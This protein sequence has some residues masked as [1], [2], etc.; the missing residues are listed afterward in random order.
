MR[1]LLISGSLRSGSANSAMLRTAFEVAPEPIEPMAFSGL[2]RLPHF[3][4]DD[5][6][7]PLPPPVVGLRAA[8]EL[9]D[10]VL[11]C[12]PEYAGALPG[13][14]KNLLEWTV[15]GTEMYRRPVGW[16]NV[17]GGGRGAATHEQ[18]RSV[19][20]YVNAEIVETACSRIPVARS[21]IGPDGRIED[22]EIRERLAALL[23]ALAAHVTADPREEIAA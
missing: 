1:V 15:G 21:Q 17:A 4:P 3:N 22:E 18:L 23:S 5:D 16:I 12:T 13:A 20:G 7:D 9:S 8:I 11:F 6:F 2:G 19:L 14:F 10:A